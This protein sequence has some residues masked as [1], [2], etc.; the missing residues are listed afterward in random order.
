MWIGI[1]VGQTLC[2]LQLI[3]AVDWRKH[4]SGEPD[5]HSHCLCAA[6]VDDGR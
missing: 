5:W 1:Y 3:G 4:G 6:A 2:L